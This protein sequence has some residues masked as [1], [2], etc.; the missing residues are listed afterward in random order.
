MSNTRLRCKLGRFTTKRKEEWKE[1][2]R[3]AAKKRKREIAEPQKLCIEGRRIVELQ[4]MAND[5]WCATCMQPLSLRFIE[6][7][8]R[9]SLATILTIRC[10]NCLATFE[11]NTCKKNFHDESGYSKYDINVKASLGKNFVNTFTLPSFI[12]NSTILYRILHF[13]ITNIF[14]FV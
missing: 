3:Q 1:N 9:I 6:N 4:Q 14:Y 8:L 12:I 13:Y 2:V 7:E 11:V 10:H 5:L